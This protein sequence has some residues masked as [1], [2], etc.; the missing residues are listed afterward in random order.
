MPAVAITGTSTDVGK[1]VVTAALA[2]LAAR[3]GLDVRVCKPV[4]T[5]LPDG[6]PGDA[7][8]AARLAGV[9]SAEFVR[10]PEPLSPIIAARRSG[11]RLWTAQELAAEA[12]RFAADEFV[13]VEG[14]GG[15]LVRLGEQGATLLDVA[16]LLRA[17]MVVVAGCELGAL[18]HAELTVRAIRAA[19]VE[20]VGLVVGSWPAEPQLAHRTNL[21]AFPEHTGVGVLGKIPRGAGSLGPGE[22]Q[23]Q[24]LGWFE[25]AHLAGLWQTSSAEERKNAGGYKER[26]Q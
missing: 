12:G 9:P 5:G 25:E 22:F 20:V 2:A 24:A 15:V 18:N 16:R 13:L 19:G 1:T 14:A 7:D 23:S 10:Y 6:E 17:P 21:E 11:R 26:T 8:E 3:R 4:Q